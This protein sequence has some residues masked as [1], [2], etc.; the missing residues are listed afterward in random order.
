MKYKQVTADEWADFCSS[1]RTY[2]TEGRESKDA[3][4]VMYH[5]LSQ[6]PDG[7]RNHWRGALPPRW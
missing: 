3:H 4:P 5:K 7:G 6:G 1:F 2:A